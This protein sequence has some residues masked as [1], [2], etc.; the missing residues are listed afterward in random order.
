MNKLSTAKRAAII[1][2]LTEG[3]SL[4]ST[5]RMTESTL[6]T[7]MRL[8]VEAGKA[9][10]A[11]QDE[12]FRN[13]KCRRLQLDEI[14]SFC[15]SKQANVPAAK[16]GQSGFGDVWTWVALDAESKLVPSWLVGSR[17]SAT[18]NAFL[19]D[20]RGRLAGRVQITSDGHKT[21]VGAVEGAFGS[22]V[23]YAMLVKLYGADLKDDTRYSPGQC[24]GTREQVIMG[25]PDT[26]HIST[27]FVE[28]SN[29][30][31]RTCMRRYT[32]LTNGFSKKLSNPMAA[33]SLHFMAYNFVR[34]QRGLGKISPAMAA[35]VTDHLW[36]VE[37][38]AALVP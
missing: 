32:R 31:M 36:S 20:L 1:A 4:R 7:C 34:D 17:D 16:Q 14:W 22:E 11:Y 38:I 3:N 25:N 23:D 13:L 28:R 15:Y 26:L 8:L 21:Y 12:H 18:A 27:S 24:L 33:V 37:E 5:S 29:L 35:G 30:T 19:T 9:C 10:A 2:A 6:N